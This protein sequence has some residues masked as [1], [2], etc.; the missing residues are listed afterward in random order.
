MVRYGLH[1][2][3]VKESMKDEL[4]EKIHSIA[5]IAKKSE[6]LD[7]PETTEIFRKIDLESSA[8]IN[9]KNLVKDSFVELS[10]GEIA[11]TNVLTKLLRLPQITGGFLS[12]DEGKKHNK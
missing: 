7:L 4:R 3:V 8:M 5:F 6:C 10:K 11:V 12:D 9:C 1:T 2:P